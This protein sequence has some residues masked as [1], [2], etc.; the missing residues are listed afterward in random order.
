MRIACT[1]RISLSVSG[2]SYA[3]T[4]QKRDPPQLLRL[5]LPMTLTSPGALLSAITLKPGISTDSAL[6]STGSPFTHASALAMA[7]DLKKRA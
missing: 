3:I 5:F 1:S 6:T 4:S 2:R 7:D